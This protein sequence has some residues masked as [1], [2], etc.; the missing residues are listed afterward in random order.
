MR[1]IYRVRGA[2]KKLE[3]ELALL[4]DPVTALG[5]Y[6]G[7]SSPFI[8]L[9]VGCSWFLGVRFHRR[10]TRVQTNPVPYILGPGRVTIGRKSV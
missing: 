2:M 7:D 5:M 8:C 4:Q 1:H 10:R 9:L 6:F 3:D